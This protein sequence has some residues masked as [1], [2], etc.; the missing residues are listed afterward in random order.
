[1]VTYATSGK[2]GG[3]SIENEGVELVPLDANNDTPFNILGGKSDTTDLEA[4][5]EWPQRN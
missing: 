2:D 4:D 3:E 1:M 5:C